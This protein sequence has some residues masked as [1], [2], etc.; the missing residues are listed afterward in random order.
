MSQEDDPSVD[1]LNSEDDDDVND[2]ADDDGGPV[3]ELG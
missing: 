2:A 3:T 1:E